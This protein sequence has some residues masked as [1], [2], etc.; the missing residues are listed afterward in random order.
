MRSLVDVLGHRDVAVC[1]STEREGS[2]HGKTPV[3]DRVVVVVVVE[4]TVERLV[5]RDGRGRIPQSVAADT[6]RACDMQDCNGWPTGSKRSDGR[7]RMMQFLQ[8]SCT[9][10]RAHTVVVVTFS[11]SSSS[12]STQASLCLAAPRG[13]SPSPALQTVALKSF[14]GGTSK[15][16]HTTS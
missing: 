6:M 5:A 15:Q 4:R 2:R 14:A 13:T 11:L 12:S 16:L 7:R 9:H 3:S 1:V 10:L 8:S